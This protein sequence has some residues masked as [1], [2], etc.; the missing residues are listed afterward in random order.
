MFLKILS[1]NNIDAQSFTPI[2]SVPLL[3]LFLFLT[4]AVV[5]GFL[6]KIPGFGKYCI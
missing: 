4:C 2:L 3:S 6:K 5:T 1:I